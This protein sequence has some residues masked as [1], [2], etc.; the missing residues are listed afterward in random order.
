MEVDMTWLDE[1]ADGDKASVRPRLT[2]SR[3]TI[4][5]DQRWLIPSLP[6]LAPEPEQPTQGR[7]KKPPPL[8]APV[9]KPTARTRLAP[10]IPREDDD[11]TQA[12]PSKKRSGP[13]SKRPPSRKS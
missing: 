4:E 5:V 13:A 6:P 8:P 10:A 11:A 12:P 1:P 7:R 9:V 2:E 3:D